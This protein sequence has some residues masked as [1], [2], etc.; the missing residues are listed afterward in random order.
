M[1]QP[2]EL[3]QRVPGKHW[4]WPTND[5]DKVTVDN[6]LEQYGITNRAEAEAFLSRLRSGIRRL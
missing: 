1:S 2:G 6:L 3:P 4:I 5:P